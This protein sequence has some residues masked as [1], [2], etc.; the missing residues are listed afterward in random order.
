MNNLAAYPTSQYI[1]HNDMRTSIDEQYYKFINSFQRPIT[2]P[3]V[4]DDLDFLFNKFIKLNQKIT[5]KQIVVLNRT[6]SYLQSFIT[7]NSSL[8]STVKLDITIDEEVVIYRKSIN[9]I[10]NII[11]D[12]DG[13]V[14]LTFASYKDNGWRNFYD[15]EEFKPS[16]HIYNFF[17]V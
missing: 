16:H 4:M 6:L 12:T 1:L 5:D 11:I 14:M 7:S 13:D 9:G 15:K 8:C 3:S 10:Y 2:S 17:S